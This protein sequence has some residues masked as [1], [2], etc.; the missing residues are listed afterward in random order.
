MLL[1]RLAPSVIRRN[2][3]GRSSWGIRPSG[4][5][6][7][8]SCTCTCANGNQVCGNGSG[9]TETEAQ[10]AAHTSGA[11]QCAAQG[12]TVSSYSFTTYPCPS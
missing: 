1:P 4:P 5:E 6:L 12:S 11:N 7:F 2:A 3:F 10:N 9:Q 8:A